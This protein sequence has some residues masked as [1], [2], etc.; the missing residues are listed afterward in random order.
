[1]IVFAVVLIVSF[2][3]E[4][5]GQQYRFWINTIPLSVFL[6]YSALVFRKELKIVLHLFSKTQNKT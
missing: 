5:S 6:I 4:I 3:N 2:Y 1:V